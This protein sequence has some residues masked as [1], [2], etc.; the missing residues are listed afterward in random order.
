M[1]T[2]FQVSKSSIPSIRAECSTDNTD[3]EQSMR[4]IDL[5][6]KQIITWFDTAPK[7]LGD[8]SNTASQH[9]LNVLEHDHTGQVLTQIITITNNSGFATQH[10]ESQL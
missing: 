7:R 9:H 6:T 5:D 4:Q 2:T 8:V 3:Q 10:P 1:L